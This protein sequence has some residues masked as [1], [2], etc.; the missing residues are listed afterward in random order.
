MYNLWVICH[1]CTEAHTESHTYREADTERHGWCWTLKLPLM[2]VHLNEHRRH[3]WNQLIRLICQGMGKRFTTQVKRPW[4]ASTCTW[5]KKVWG[6]PGLLNTWATWQRWHIFCQIVWEGGSILR[7]IGLRTKASLAR[8]Q[9]LQQQVGALLRVLSP[10]ALSYSD[11]LS[12]AALSFS[13]NHY[14]RAA[15]GITVL[16]ILITKEPLLYLRFQA[17]CL[18]GVERLAGSYLGRLN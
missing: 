1:T 17:N 3:H 12:P 15:T 5:D 2:Q 14:Y 10:A 18:L 8:E 7:R 13:D 4:N 11:N 6:I 9:L 16:F